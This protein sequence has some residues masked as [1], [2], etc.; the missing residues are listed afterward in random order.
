[1]KRASRKKRKGLRLLL[2]ALLIIVLGGT[3]Y[4][5]VQYKNH[6]AL[7]EIDANGVSTYDPIISM[8][9][10][11]VDYVAYENATDS[12]E[13][14]RVDEDN[15]TISQN[16]DMPVKT[17]PLNNLI[18]SAS[19]V[20]PTAIIADTLDDMAT[21]GLDEPSYKL[22]IRDT[23]GTSVTL[24]LGKKN[25]YSNSYY[26]YV[27]GDSHIYMV[28]NTLATRMDNTLYDFCNAN[29]TAFDYASAI[30]AA[31]SENGNL[32]MA[33]QKYDTAQL[34]I[35][36]CNLY[37]WYLTG[38]EGKRQPSDPDTCSAYLEAIGEISAGDCVDY[39]AD[40][41]KLAEYGLDEAN[42]VRFDL[43]SN[44][45]TEDTEQ[46][47]W[48]G[49]Q[50]D[51]GSYYFRCS[52][53]DGVFLVDQSS[54]EAVLSYSERQFWSKGFSIVNIDDVNSVDVTIDGKTRTLSIE[55]EEVAVEADAD[56]TEESDEAAATETVCTYYVDG[57][58]WEETDFKNLYTNI[59]MILGDRP[60][61]EEETP[62]E[63]DPYVT[64]VFHTSLEHFPEVTI[65]YTYFDSNFYQ[66]TANGE[67][68]MLVNR[69]SI[70][71]LAEEFAD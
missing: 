25:S 36:W 41:E 22:T 63:V 35:T 69:N 68:Q 47:Y 13:F 21:Y 54:A 48:F 43:V 29:Q 24:Y 49:A 10:D 8:N 6:K 70:S 4:G 44:D 11:D 59:I 58:E 42:A 67:T 34:D 71:S 26:A 64:V 55:R 7:E 56:S 15:W 19:A 32:I 2:L 28:T 38:T 17:Y 18:A 60:L 33:V 37:Y 66:A 65:E 46:T 45:G 23:N 57:E 9:S 51:D 30:Y 14:T 53:S 39:T 40:E 62:V 16:P 27:E 50:A 31:R 3:Y 12:L 1:M 20:S 52:D 61:S 5:V